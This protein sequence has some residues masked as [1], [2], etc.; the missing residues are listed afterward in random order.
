MNQPFKRCYVFGDFRVDGAERRL[1]RGGAVISLAPKVFDTLLL[2][3]ENSGHLVEKDEF[4]KQLWPDTFVGEDALVRNISILR[5]VLGESRDSQAFIAT[6][7]TRGYRFV[8]AV[9]KVNS[10]SV[11]FLSERPATKQE[12][13]HDEHSAVARPADVERASARDGSPTPEVAVLPKWRRRIAFFASVLGVGS[14]AG[15]ATF[16][17]LSPSPVP[18]VIRSVQLT[19]S[20]RVE[21]WMSMVSD[22]SRIY[23]LEREGDHWNLMQTSV[24]G[25]DSQVVAAPFRD[26]IIRDISP[27]RANFLIASFVHRNDLMPLWI[28]PVQGGAPK[29]VGDIT[30]LEA[31]WCPNG[32]EIVYSK[33]DGIYLVD[34][35]GANAHKL[36]AVEG[37]ADHFSWSADGRLL[38]FS[39][40][41]T[42]TRTGALWEVH[43][44]GTK[45]RRLLSGWSEVSLECCASWTPDG[46]YFL[47]SSRHSGIGDVWSIQE[48]SSLFHRPRAEPIRLTAGPTDF[49]NPLASKDGRKV[50][51]YGSNGKSESV[52]YDLKSR[53]FLPLLPG[54]PVRSLN[55][56]AN[57]EWV[58]SV[59]PDST[60]SRMKP[61]GTQGL[62]LTPPSIEADNPRWSPDGKQIAFTG[63]RKSRTLRIYLVSPDGGTPRELFPDDHN[64]HDPAWSPDGKLI[65]LTREEKPSSPG[66]VSDAIYILNLSTNQL[67]LIPG[68]QGLHAPTWSPDGRF[69]AAKDEDDHKLML[70]DVHT[71]KWTQ[72]AEAL[73]IRGPH[74]PFN[75]GKYIYY[76]DGLAP[77]Q[78][79]YSI[80]LSDHKR[81]SVVTFEPF[82][83]GTAISVGFFGVA[84]DGSIMASVARNDSD[85]Y[86]LDLDLP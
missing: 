53:Q 38:R 27:D 45:L 55:F 62:V 86:A 41:T 1:L 37:H 11:Q 39:V 31:A 14:L 54:L 19:H 51:V 8:A 74:W 15:L 64:Q 13:Q 69:I 33:D 43:S 75:D 40:W 83:R 50:F 22:G 81:E 73:A 3:V 29:R 71:Q 24:A 49:G 16:Y 2:L 26:T 4:M 20:G 10:G 79:V 21:T 6:V 30:A 17:L 25:G 61:D 85:I 47:L 77:N 52:R 48:K 59:S 32:R 9:E 67:S 66:A 36:V 18:R 72:L 56:S 44:D 76:Q 80:R 23:F 57:Q 82:L 12:Q 58:A 78:P 70:F 84:P 35:D 34:I 7:P 5:K 68:S 46:R 65:A 60:L 42:E 28:W 63:M